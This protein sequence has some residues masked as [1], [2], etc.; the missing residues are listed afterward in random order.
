MTTETTRSHVGWW[1]GT[2]LMAI[3]VAVA[4]LVGG[5]DH[6]WLAPAGVTIAM[7]VAWGFSYG[8]ASHAPWRREGARP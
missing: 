3:P 6:D 7:A 2:V 4:W 1:C 8:T 5:S